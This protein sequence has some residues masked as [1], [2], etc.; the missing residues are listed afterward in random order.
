M[1]LYGITTCMQHSNIIYTKDFPFSADKGAF[2][3]F[4]L[5]FYYYN[6]YMTN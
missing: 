5:F 1:Q 3:A 4:R 6:L 2:G